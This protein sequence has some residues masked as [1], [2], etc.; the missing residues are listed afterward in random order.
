MNEDT[1]KIVAA[2]DRN[3][4]AVQ[5]QTQWLQV[6]EEDPSLDVL[7][8]I[9]GLLRLLCAV[10]TF[11]VIAY[12]AKA[13]PILST[14]EPTYEIGVPPMPPPNPNLQHWHTTYVPTD[15]G[16]YPLEVFAPV[17]PKIEFQRMETSEPM[18]A[19]PEPGILTVSGLSILG[20]MFL[21]LLLLNRNSKIVELTK[22]LRE[23]YERNARYYYALKQIEDYGGFAPTVVIARKALEE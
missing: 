10:L 2:I 18:V 21:N 12:V 7:M 11:W 3:T 16:V 17:L 9:R 4:E 19:T 1:D 8:Q 14:A 20:M 15:N 6:E 5:A 13:S 23:A 22:A